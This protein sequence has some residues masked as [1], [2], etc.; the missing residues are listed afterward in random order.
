[1][2]PIIK[3]IRYNKWNFGTKLKKKRGIKKSACVGKT[4]GKTGTGEFKQMGK[5][6][7]ISNANFIEMSD[8]REN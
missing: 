7:N 6:N 2:R 3:T 4:L 5:K 1:M 8:D